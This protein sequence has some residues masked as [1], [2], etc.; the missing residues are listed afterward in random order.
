[1]EEDF[2]AAAAVVAAAVVAAAVVAAA[3]VA[4]AAAAAAVK[5]V[6][7]EVVVWLELREALPL[8]HLWE[9]HHCLA[10]ALK[11]SDVMFCFL[12]EGYLQIVR[13]ISTVVL[14]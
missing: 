10:R 8:S 14:K 6:A 9:L 7:V 2:V 5:V 3:V 13:E 11:P 1:L 4:V 12:S